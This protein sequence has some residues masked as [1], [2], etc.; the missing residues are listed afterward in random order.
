MAN[1]TGKGPFHKRSQFRNHCI[2]LPT[3]QPPMLAIRKI[4]AIEGKDVSE[5][6]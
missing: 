2:Q 5:F 4:I 3:Y 1:S 6:S